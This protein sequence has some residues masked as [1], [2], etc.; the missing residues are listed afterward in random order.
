M[1]AVEKKAKYM[2]NDLGLLEDNVKY[3]PLTVSIKVL[4]CDTISRR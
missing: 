2:L 1:D 3:T 4:N